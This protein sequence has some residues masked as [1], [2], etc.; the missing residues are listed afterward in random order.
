MA[1]GN[2]Q[3]ALDNTNTTYQQLVDISNDIVNKCVKDITPIILNINRD[4]ENISND[5]IRTYMLTLS[6]KAYSLAEIKEKAS[7]K[8]EVAEILKKEAYATEFNGADGTVAVREN[9][10][11]INISDEILAQT[12]NELVSGILKVKLEELHRIIDTLKSILMSRLS[13]AKLI[14]VSD[15]IT[16]E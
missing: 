2:L 4:I 14:S 1:R 8:A 5:Q 16:N 13:E 9:L 3:L 15:G 12:V 10:A 7:M 6:L 11:Q